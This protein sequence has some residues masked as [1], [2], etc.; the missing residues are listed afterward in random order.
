[1]HLGLCGTVAGRCA[2]R[3]PGAHRRRA[4]SAAAYSLKRLR[5]VS[6]PFLACESATIADTLVCCVMTSVRPLSSSV[7]VMV[8]VMPPSTPG[9][10]HAGLGPRRARSTQPQG[11]YVLI[12]PVIAVLPHLPVAAYP[13][14]RGIE[15]AGFEPGQDRASRRICQCGERDAQVVAD[16]CRRHRS[17]SP[18]RRAPGPLNRSRGIVRPATSRRRSRLCPVSG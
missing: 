14:G 10:V 7:K 5:L 4:V 1:M 15:L 11:G 12:E 18:S 6:K 3:D 17:A 8:V 16:C 9:S 2:I 13:F